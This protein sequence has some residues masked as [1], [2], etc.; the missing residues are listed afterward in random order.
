MRYALL[1]MIIAFAVAFPTMVGAQGAGSR[2]AV[3]PAHAPSDTRMSDDDVA[4]ATTNAFAEC[5]L[6]R[7]AGGVA[8][9]VAL[10]PGA[11]SGEALA[12]LATD[13]CLNDGQLRIPRVLMRGAA[14]VAMYRRDYGR[15][16]AALRE[17]PLDYA[18]DIPP[19]AVGLRQQAA[20]RNYTSCVMRRNF[21]DSRQFVLGR[22]G[23]QGERQAIAGLGPS[24]SACL[25]EGSTLK[26]SKSV[27]QGALAET[28]YRETIPVAAARSGKN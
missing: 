3:E 2:L 26:F 7:N 21:A 4:R 25:P 14:Y 13:D 1:F 12:H 6:K 10:P 28:L 8:R 17:T 5:L 19:Y 16:D 23:T 18:A 22:V 20:L 11:G 9:A 15:Q 27:I 24:L